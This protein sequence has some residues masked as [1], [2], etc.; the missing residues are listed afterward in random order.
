MQM[1]VHKPTDRSTH[2]QY[3]SVISCFGKANIVT[4][5]S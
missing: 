2:Y 3:C 5:I 4:E 1:K